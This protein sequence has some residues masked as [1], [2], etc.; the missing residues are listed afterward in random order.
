MRR[1]LL[2]FVLSILAIIIAII[3]TAF[4]QQ[5]EAY[6]E[7]GSINQGY[8]CSDDVCK[9]DEKTLFNNVYVINLDKRPDRWQQTLKRLQDIGITDPIRWSATDATDIKDVYNITRKEI[10]LGEF[11]CYLSHKK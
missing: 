11:G 10:T 2:L 1:L 5:K 7:V 8:I 9:V 3:I 6:G 4:A